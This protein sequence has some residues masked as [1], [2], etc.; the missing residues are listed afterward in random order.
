MVFSTLLFIFIYFVVVL[1]VYYAF[2]NRKYRNIVL[3][4]F[5]LIFY[6]WGEPTFLILMVFSILFNYA[7][8]LLV[9]KYRDNKKKSKTAL[10]ISI[11]VNLLLLAVFKY[12]AFVLDTLKSFLP[13]LRSFATPVIPLPIGISFYTFQAMSYVIDVY[14]GDTEVQRNPIYFGTYVSLFP[15]LIAGPIVRYKDVANELEHRR[16][17]IPQF[18]DGIKLFAI[19][20]AKKVLIANQMAALWAVLRD[21]SA[22]NGVL[23]SWVGLIAFTLQI[24]FDFCGY[25]EMAIGLGRMFG[26]EFLKNFDYPYISK[27]VSE[28]WRRWHI[29]LGTWFREYVYIPLGGNRK[30][31]ARLFLNTA[32]VWFL[33]GLWHG[34]SWNFVLWGMY[35][36]ILI[37]L[38]KLFLGKLLKKLPNFVQHLY[39]IFLFTFGWALFDFVEIDKLGPFIVSLFNGGTVGLISKDALVYAV[40]YLPIMVVAIVASTPLAKTIHDRYKDRTWCRC[41]DIALVMLSL[42]F[43]TAALVKGGYNPFIYFRF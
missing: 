16:E 43:C 21:T 29:S 36:G 1:A 17:N 7:F 23:G 41:V 22:T 5:S 38:E 18:A 3:C 33:T 26:F 40:A 10:V 14:R 39:A 25:S 9:E 34:A 32:I 4:F 35:F 12:T 8:G 42:V 20:L 13:F 19:G 30:G 37:C 11:V 15:Q 6:G 2:P 28:F 27:S 24:Y 31:L